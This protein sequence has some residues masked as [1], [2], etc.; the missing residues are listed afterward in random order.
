MTVNSSPSTFTRSGNPAP[1]SPRLYLR[2]DELDSGVSLILDAGQML[3]SATLSQREAFGLAWTEARC[4]WEVLGQPRPVLALAAAL[5]LTKQTMIKT[6][7][8]LEG[9]GLILRTNDPQDGRRKRVILTKDGE[10]MAQELALA[11]RA[12]LAQAYKTAGSEAVAGCD[13]VLTLLNQA[14]KPANRSR[15]KI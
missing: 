9:R 8:G 10:V 1:G 7:E 3:K 12:C 11:M 2:E 5:G 6:L 4:L 15:S 13:K 14:P